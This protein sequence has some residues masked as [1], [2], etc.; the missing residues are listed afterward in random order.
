MANNAR[1]TLVFDVQQDGTLKLAT[2]NLNDAAQ[3]ANNLNTAQNR[4][5]QGARNHNE[6]INGGVASANNGTRGFAKLK[7]S[8]DGSN[9]VVAAYAT[10]ATQAFAVSA[11]FSKL[12]EAAQT[13]QL[14]RGLAEQGI[15]TGNS[16]NATAR[17][18]QEVTGYAI[19]MGDAMRGAAQ[20]AAAGFNPTTMVALTQAATDASAALGRNVPDALDRFIK[21]TTKLEPELLD[22]MGIMVKLEQATSQY[23]QSIGKMPSQLTATEK[24]TGYLNAVLDES[25]LKFEGM[26]N[27]AG[28][29]PY[30]KLSA[31]F[32]DLINNVLTTLN[33]AG[34]IDFVQ[35][36]ANNTQFLVTT[37]IWFGSTIIKQVIPGLY[38]TASA[39]ATAAAAL[40]DEAAATH[41]AAEEAEDK[42]KADRAAA[43][44]QAKTLSILETNNKAYTEYAAAV[45][46][47]TETDKQKASALQSLGG[48]QGALTRTIKALEDV[49]KNGQAID[50]AEL[51]RLKALRSEYA[52]QAAAIRNLED[53]KRKAQ[54]QDTAGQAL[55]DRL[56]AQA[57]IADK[58]ANAKGSFAEALEAGGE[59]DISDAFGKIKEG[60]AEMKQGLLESTKLNGTFS[61]RFK[62]GF[63]GIVDKIKGAGLA[64][65]GFIS[66]YEGVSRTSRILDF[67]KAGWV[68][69]GASITSAGGI[70]NFAKLAF[71]GLAMSVK[72][73]GLA[74]LNAIPIIGQV[75]MII[76]LVIEY[77]GTAWEWIKN[78]F[79]T[80]EEKAYAKRIKDA[81]AAVE[82]AN[83]KIEESQK[84][85]NESI[86]NSI[87]IGNRFRD[88][89]RGA[90][91]DANKQAQAIIAVNN[92]IADMVSRLQ[93]LREQEGA[94]DALTQELNR[95]AQ[96]APTAARGLL[97]TNNAAFAQTEEFRVLS[98]I[99]ANTTEA[100]KAKILE[101]MEA[102]SKKPNVEGMQEA[103]RQGLAPI[104]EAA[105]KTSQNVT[106]L[107]SSMTA[108]DKAAQDFA[109][110]LVQT[111]SYDKMIDSLQE[112]NNVISNLKEELTS[113]SSKQDIA[114]TVNEIASKISNSMVGL[115]SEGAQ[116]ALMEFKAYQAVAEEYN[117]LA[118]QN[119]DNQ[120][121]HNSYLQVSSKIQTE[122]NNKAQT[123]LDTITQGL[124]AAQ[125]RLLQA[126]TEERTIQSMIALENARY[127]INQRMNGETKESAMAQDAHEDRLIAL[128][129]QK[130]AAQRSILEAQIAGI[131][132]QKTE[133]RFKAAAYRIAA[134]TLKVELDS[135]KARNAT[136]REQERLEGARPTVTAT[137][138]S[139]QAVARG[140]GTN[141]EYE[142]QTQ[143]QR[144]YDARH[145]LILST[146]IAIASL[147]EAYS[148]AEAS[149]A[150]MTQQAEAFNTAS[151]NTVKS[152]RD[153]QTA[154]SNLSAQ[155]T[156]GQQTGAE[157]SARNIGIELRIVQGIS[158]DINQLGSIYLDLLRQ[159]E[160]IRTKGLPAIVTEAR[161]AK[162]NLATSLQEI[163]NNR[164]AGKQA[165]EQR[166]LELEATAR[167][168]GLNDVTRRQV[169]AEL[170]LAQAR[171]D[172]YNDI[173]TAMEQQARQTAQTAL[174]ELAY[175]NTS[176]EG[177]EIQQNA[178]ELISK[179]VDEQEKLADTISRGQQ[180][181]AQIAARRR[182]RELDP[183]EQR[184]LDLTA[185]TRA[186]AVAEEQLDIKIQGI[187]LEYALLEAQR[188]QTVLELTTKKRILEAQLRAS[189]NGSLTADQQVMLN[190]LTGALDT[191]GRNSYNNIRDIAIQNARE[192]VNNKRREVQLLSIN[193]G[194]VNASDDILS[195]V[196]RA[197]DV[198]R[199]IATQQSQRQPL[200][201]RIDLAGVFNTQGSPIVPDLNKALEDGL[202][203]ISAADAGLD[204]V[205]RPVALTFQNLDEVIA[206][207]SLR[208]ERLGQTLDNI[209]PE[210]L[211][212]LRELEGP[213]RSTT[214]AAPT[215]GNI[216]LAT[217]RTASGVTAQVRADLA[218]NF[219]GFIRE[220]EA[221][222]YRISTLSGYRPGATVK[223]LDGEDTGRP[224]A[225]GAAASI[226]INGGTNPHRRNLVTDL[227]SNVGDIA[228]K[229]GL[230]WGGNWAS[231]KDAMHFSGLVSEGGSLVRSLTA[232][233]SATETQTRATRETTERAVETPVPTAARATAVV[234]ETP[235]ARAAREAA[236][237]ARVESE[238][239][240]RETQARSRISE[241]VAQQTDVNIDRLVQNAINQRFGTNF[242]SG[243]TAE[244]SQTKLDAMGLSS[245]GKDR[246]TQYV[247]EVQT[248][249]S[250]LQDR[251]YQEIFGN[252]KLEAM[253]SDE[254]SKAVE[255]FKTTYAEQMGGLA[256]TAYEKAFP[257]GALNE[258]LTAF[259]TEAS[260]TTQPFLN[261]LKTLGPDGEL[262]SSIYSGVQNITT[263][264]SGLAATLESGSAGFQDYAKVASAVISSVG[265][266]LASGSKTKIANIDKE[267]AAEE[268]RDGKSKES[269]AKL[270]AL[271]K[272]KEA[273]ERKA[274][275]RDKKIK[276]AQTVISTAAAIAK[277]IGE[278]GA[279]AIPLAIAVG[280]LGM[281]QL[282]I[283]AGTSFQGS[284]SADL[285]ASMPTTLSIGKRS[286][287]V[288]LASGPNANAGGEAGYI[289]GTSGYG[290]N[291]GN[292][293][294]LGSAYG[295]DLTR[296]Y[297]NRGFIVGEKGPELITP[298]TPINV[299]P[300]NENTAS[301]PVNAT[302]N[303]Q[304]IDSQGVQD[305]L[306]AQKG[307]I[308]QMLRQAANASGQRFLEDVNV[309]VYTRP[310][311]GK[312]L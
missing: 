136:A 200:Q 18:M 106:D 251:L 202:S 244:Q 34:L 231:S 10:L 194:L 41:K 217:I 43:I 4:A 160:S 99:F 94:R 59:G 27:A 306:V 76:Q 238:R 186:L 168:N 87:V 207:T 44:E 13:E 218:E 177:L 80:D 255:I 85:L 97:Q 103:A 141:A 144:A 181:E 226:D 292:Y 222:G 22:E 274:F 23:A 6:A 128:Q 33:D 82:E 223:N 235:E 260:T 2:R 81:E 210:T 56:G 286:D 112:V 63:A 305:V 225:H 11:A 304:A 266:I 157:R 39:A 276:M 307:N 54:T 185:A 135:L 245:G 52:K 154:L 224:S 69:L 282:A 263:S 269:V 133:L 300:A 229:W 104:G 197:Q 211:Q 174:L 297:G 37:L 189:Q 116:D 110:S 55:V 7:Q 212:S 241:S 127:Q 122:I 215:N 50:E 142:A 24:R 273:E 31:A 5:A 187:Q 291:A 190:Q 178:L 134:D 287:T 139:E 206:Q 51:Q 98:A 285:G 191:L 78:L 198:A 73:L 250:E 158:A 310:S 166:K 155:L 259:W 296:G 75:I 294:T 92:N 299:T 193:T 68:S 121:L 25:R 275:E 254:A 180:L 283:I 126:Q 14:M 62:A 26:A 29:N 146:D 105:L 125:Q 71:T 114:T 58:M 153:A 301:N 230:G 264:I 132:A 19:S 118:I 109:R 213:N 262:V 36:L 175:V 148:G 281:A 236:D 199:T 247:Q 9:G 227:P 101:L 143:A 234:G 84:A 184:Q 159:Q 278:G 120:V 228:R 64:V 272:K 1:I 221:T 249:G 74:M 252:G 298:E 246:L 45:K 176:K 267:I 290:S 32:T 95:L 258:K 237:A 242:Q 124:E 201:D 220:L 248:S 164:T 65:K 216:S 77:A 183:E 67:V 293:N 169:E 140:L 311:V 208:F 232:L 302:F 214:A 48:Q 83:K 205:F 117:T 49:K 182:G 111:T 90:A 162:Q 123:Y 119:R 261:S 240:A 152:L 161:L 86:E 239:V 270:A 257:M 16:L 156:V 188:V 280:A 35:R 147:T 100:N 303:I 129:Q 219:Q 170:S 115:M 312:L 309:N 79:R 42:A 66:G 149:V 8:I 61:E 46:A 28:I 165:L 179:R 53:E 271:K 47:G 192:E 151:D 96:A 91:V 279:F 70:M 209:L 38:G 102:L 88:Y 204:E 172:V 195:N 145:N 12:R 40:R 131:E 243:D 277:T 30:D 93:D 203:N 57:N 171:L 265:N 295:G 113:K 167:R 289:R 173:T 253:S 288:N 138:F 89:L 3:A 107:Q 284:E 256:Q 60:L 130:L 268:K 233:T 137:Q 20:V 308:I 150:R 163:A 17:T 15:R 108:A 21:G 72:V 196:L